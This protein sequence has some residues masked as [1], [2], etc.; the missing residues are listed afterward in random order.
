MGFVIIDFKKRRDRET[1]QSLVP[2]TVRNV[3][4]FIKSYTPEEDLPP[5]ESE[6]A[7]IEEELMSTTLAEFDEVAG[8]LWRAKQDL[9]G[10]RSRLVIQL[11]RREGKLFSRFSDSVAELEDLAATMMEECMNRLEDTEE[12]LKA[13]LPTSTASIDSAFD[14]LVKDCAEYIEEDFPEGVE[15]IKA[16]DENLEP[17][18]EALVEIIETKKNE[19]Y[20]AANADAIPEKLEKVKE[21][22]KIMVQKSMNKAIKAQLLKIEKDMSEDDTLPYLDEEAMG[23]LKT[24]LIE[25]AREYAESR[26]DEDF[27][28]DDEYDCDDSEGEDVK[29]EVDE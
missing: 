20:P 24:E 22:S 2:E 18:F 4:N 10:R 12:E 9:P 3:D 7:A 17:T 6:C 28:N 26:I 21:R 27:S 11:K 14:E 29:G 19:E 23:D 16:Y 1:L 13:S 25:A 15:G 8:K 5:N